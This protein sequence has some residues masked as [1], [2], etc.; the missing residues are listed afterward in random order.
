MSK[1]SEKRAT[2]ADIIKEKLTEKQ[3]EIFTIYSGMDVGLKKYFCKTLKFCTNKTLIKWTVMFFV[4]YLILKNYNINI[5]PRWMHSFNK[6]KKKNLCSG[7][8]ILVTFIFYF[9][10]DCING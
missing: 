3:T 10:F 9:M 5:L 7:Q 2:L 4:L 8:I 1:D 6:K